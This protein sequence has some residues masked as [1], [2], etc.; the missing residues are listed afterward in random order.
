MVLA[1]ALEETRLPAPIHVEDRGV[2]GEI[3]Y[4]VGYGQKLSQSF[5]YASQ[6]WVG[7]SLG[8]H[9]LRHRYAKSRVKT[10]IELVGFERARYLVS[11]EVGHFR[12]Q[13]TNC[14]L[15]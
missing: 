5:S 7:F 13:I 1:N 4:D 10:L 3:I 8:F 15:S 12:P 14:Y 6:K 9:G 11:Q 2:F